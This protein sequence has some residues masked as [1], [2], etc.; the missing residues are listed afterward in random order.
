M[1]RTLYM[2]VRSIVHVHTEGERESKRKIKL[3]FG[4]FL[5]LLRLSS[6]NVEIICRSFFLRLLLWHK[7]LLNNPFFSSLENLLPN[8]HARAR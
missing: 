8:Y 6:H 4:A 2:L 1:S 3:K 5:I 7:K